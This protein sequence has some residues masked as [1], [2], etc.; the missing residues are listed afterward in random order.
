MKTQLTKPAR[1][2]ASYT[3]E[4]REEALEL[5]RARAAGVEGVRGQS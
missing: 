3:K 1:G 4:Y 2:R 5:W